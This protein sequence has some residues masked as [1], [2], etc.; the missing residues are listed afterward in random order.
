[1]KRGTPWQSP[2]STGRRLDGRGYLMSFPPGVS[3]L[4]SRPVG[5]PQMPRPI[6]FATETLHAVAAAHVPDELSPTERTSMLEQLTMAVGRSP[7][8]RQLGTHGSDNV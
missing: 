7:P 8:G 2:V 6:R 5:F 3:T 4:Q 1:M